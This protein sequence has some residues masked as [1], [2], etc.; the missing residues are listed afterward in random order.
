MLNDDGAA[1]WEGAL[2]SVVDGDSQ[3]EHQS[4]DAS[5][6][7]ESQA[8]NGA[9]HE[10]FDIEFDAPTHRRRVAKLASS[11]SATRMSYAKNQGGPDALKHMS[12]VSLGGEDTRRAVGGSSMVAFE[13]FDKNQMQGFFRRLWI[14]ITLA[15]VYVLANLS[16]VAYCSQDS[17][18]EA[19][20]TE[21]VQNNCLAEHLMGDLGNRSAHE[22]WANCC[23]P[24][25][26][27]NQSAECFVRDY[28][29]F[30][31]TAL[32]IAEES[33]A[34]CCSMDLQQVFN[35]CP[36]QCIFELIN[37]VVRLALTLAITV[38]LVIYTARFCSHPKT[39]V[40][41]EQKFVVVLFV[42]SLILTNPYG[43]YLAL[44]S[45]IDFDGGL[46]NGRSEAATESEGETALLVGSII[47]A[48]FGALICG[49][50]IVF[51]M[52]YRLTT[53]YWTE[54]NFCAR[55]FRSIRSLG[56]RFLMYGLLL[57]LYIVLRVVLALL[58]NDTFEPVYIGAVPLFPALVLLLRLCGWQAAPP[59][60][61]F[62]SD[63]LVES[64]YEPDDFI[65]SCGQ[66]PETV[67]YVVAIL[68]TDVLLLVLI[69]TET[70]AT[71][72]QLLHVGY[73]QS[74]TL[75]VT[76][77]FFVTLTVSMVMAL[78]ICG[79]V[80]SLFLPTLHFWRRVDSEVT[81]HNVSAYH[82][83]FLLGATGGESVGGSAVLCFLSA[84]WT[85][86]MAFIYLPEN[87]KPGLAGCFRDVPNYSRLARLSNRPDYQ[88]TAK[89]ANNRYFQSRA[90][91][92]KH[93]Q[94][95]SHLSSVMS[96]QATAEQR[97]ND[98]VHESLSNPRAD[99]PVDQRHHASAPDRENVFVFETVLIMCALADFAYNAYRAK[100]PSPTDDSQPDDVGSSDAG[101]G[102]PPKQPRRLSASSDISDA[103]DKSS[104][105]A[106][107]EE[108][109]DAR[110]ARWQRNLDARLCSVKEASTLAEQTTSAQ[111]A[112]LED[113]KNPKRFRTCPEW[114]L[115]IDST[116][117]D[118]VVIEDHVDDC[119]YVAFKGTS[120][121]VN[122]LDDLK[123]NLVPFEL[124]NHL[125]QAHARGRSGLVGDS[126]TLTHLMKANVHAGFQRVYMS[127]REDLLALVEAVLTKRR[128]KLRITGHSL[129]G[130][131]ATLFALDAVT[132]LASPRDVC[133]TTFGS[134]RVGNRAFAALFDHH[135]RCAW[136][137]ANQFD[138]ITRVP[139]AILGGSRGNYRHVG[140]FVLVFTNGD[141]VIDPSV[142]EKNF[143]HGFRV[144][145][146]RHQMVSYVVDATRLHV[147][148]Q[149]FGAVLTAL[150]SFAGTY[151]D[152]WLGIIVQN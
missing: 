144:K 145:F 134:P 25:G 126:L 99:R 68:A 50:V 106:L 88:H 28:N 113:V 19:G 32:S 31:E 43:S 142:I 100:T 45:H 85:F 139:Q 62:Y 34:Q 47:S 37:V 128:R 75:Q 49:F 70:N 112:S 13:M 115:H 44:V 40:R 65:G 58:A 11:T 71:R 38:G 96:P 16:Q 12:V 5:P 91:L 42:L 109:T 133:V 53:K 26:Q 135:V 90:L 23:R 136:R 122:A 21:H 140:K 148:V 67:G 101:K 7:Q 129:G 78:E 73:A 141:I 39:M 114:V 138:G 76:F 64:G 103:S 95:V 137:V 110:H 143:L 92:R 9:F 14:M 79:S 24:L 131:L 81:A 84:V 17:F 41:F 59:F 83:L 111:D 150:C 4:G 55:S 130:A 97:A 57:A 147:L 123:M 102:T 152:F 2:N 72:F 46:C 3:D 20:F 27:G 56:Y 30:N 74:R 94:R 6:D 119:Y 10:D 89:A 86:S 8:E 149:P 146:N 80:Y 69:F 132:S 82:P 66:S 29:R 127:V 121:L 117:T 104:T 54:G 124:R 105:A 120:S 61:E 63:L 108:S 125:A 15:G 93:G 116:D 118:V 51:L 77:R 33:F 151:L 1:S 35:S 52:S 22:V 36:S 48:V 60:T 87:A 107:V 98:A 18:Y